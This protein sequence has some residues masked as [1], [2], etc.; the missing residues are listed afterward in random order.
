MKAAVWKE[1]HALKELFVK[2]EADLSNYL[3][4]YKNAYYTDADLSRFDGLDF[5]KLCWYTFMVKVVREAIVQLDFGDAS[6]VACK[7]HTPLGGHHPRL[8]DDHL[9]HVLHLPGQ[10]CCSPFARRLSPSR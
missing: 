9:G 8:F 2:N 4:V 6:A 5:K 1:I 7:S 10:L 3:A